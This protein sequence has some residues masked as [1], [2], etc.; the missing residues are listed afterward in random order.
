[1]R[2]IKFRGRR[3][4]VQW[5]YGD[6]VRQEDTILGDITCC[7]FP[8][9]AYDSYDN[10]IVDQQTVGQYTNRKDK[11]GVEIYEGDIVKTKCNVGVVRYNAKHWFYEV[12]SPDESLGN[13][14][15]PAGVPEEDWEVLGNIH[16]NPELL[17]IVGYYATPEEEKND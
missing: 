17:D 5:I 10:Y 3:A 8:A 9:Q 13:E 2:Q 11:H 6:L 16:D 12:A 1:M 14:R 7:V 15:I 4:N